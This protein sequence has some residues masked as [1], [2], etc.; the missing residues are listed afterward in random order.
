MIVLAYI[1]LYAVTERQQTL[2]E[3]NIAF[4]SRLHNFL[5]ESQSTYMKIYTL[6][7]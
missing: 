5:R 6:R 2:D 3:I 7:N 1:Y 4:L